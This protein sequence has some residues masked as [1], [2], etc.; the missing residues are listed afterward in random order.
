[1]SNVLCKCGS[2]LGNTGLPS[3]SPTGKVIKK[4]VFV[5]MVSSAGTLYSINPA[6]TLTKSGFLTPALNNA[7]KS[8]RLFPTPEILDVVLD[9][10]DPTF[11]KYK[12]GASFF[13]REGVRTFVGVIPDCPPL[14]KSKLESVRCN[15][16][17]GVYLVDIEN[18]WIG[19]TNEVDGKLY[20]F[21]INVQSMVGKVAFGADDDVQ[22]VMVNFEFPPAVRD[23][24]IRMI[25]GGNF[26]D[27]QLGDIN[28][29]LDANYA[30]VSV[31][32]TVLTVD[33][34]TPS[35]ALDQ[36]IP[37]QGMVTADFI[38]S[39]TA[40]T[41]KIYNITDAADDTVTVVEDVSGAHPGRYAISYSTIAA[42]T[43]QLA[44]KKNGYDFT[45]FLTGA[46]TVT[47]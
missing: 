17:T 23:G 34:T 40:T 10:E 19:L 37:I 20:P 28:G 5:Q 26:T 21:P 22:S 32:D 13:V 38:S 18:N 41:S 14:Y 9:K 43:L 7:D 3:C 8:L 4:V 47:P 35:P 44:A 36:N 45:N 2:G 42:K 39:S 29:L 1:M 30:V 27:W 31:T 25:S 33:I 24:D 11:K 15:S 12:S 16:N 6:T 46:A